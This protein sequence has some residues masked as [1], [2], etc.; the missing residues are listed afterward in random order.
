MQEHFPG[1]MLLEA[2]DPCAADFD[3]NETSTSPIHPVLVDGHPWINHTTVDL[4]FK[5]S[6]PDGYRPIVLCNF[7]LTARTLLVQLFAANIQLKY[8]PKLWRS[9]EVI[10]L[11]K[12]GKT[13]LHRTSSV[14]LYLP[15]AFSF[16]NLGKIS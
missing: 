4:A 15:N 10:F 11:P 9:S 2:K 12:P 13:R 5:Q 3:P 8:T 1:S 16:Q 14:L 7:P 6:G